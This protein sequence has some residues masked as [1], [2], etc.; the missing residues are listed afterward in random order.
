MGVA[1]SVFKQYNISDKPVPMAVL[2]CVCMGLHDTLTTMLA[3]SLYPLL[4]L[5]TPFPKEQNAVFHGCSKRKMLQSIT[6]LFCSTAA[7]WFSCE[8]IPWTAP[9]S[10]SLSWCVPRGWTGRAHASHRHC[11]SG[12]PFAIARLP[13]ADVWQERNIHKY[14]HDDNN[15]FLYPYIYGYASLGKESFAN[16]TRYLMCYVYQTSCSL[17]L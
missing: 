13:Y 1:S 14:D 7:P 6:V 3:P 4:L 2:C 16:T 15:N 5:H 11:K 9:G 8:P 17:M 12:F 10:Y